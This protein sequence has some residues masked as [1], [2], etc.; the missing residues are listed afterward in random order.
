MKHTEV[1]KPEY[2]DEYV[3]THRML[4]RT[5]SIMISDVNFIKACVDLNDVELHHDWIS[6]KYLHGVVF[7]DLIMRTYKAFFDNK[8]TDATNLFK[9]KNSVKG[10]YLKPEYV[11]RVKVDI[12]TSRL[13]A[14]KEYKKTRLE[15]LSKNIIY[16]HDKYVGH[17]ILNAKEE[18]KVNLSDIKELLEYGCELF[19]RLSFEPKG[20]YD[21]LLESDGYD[22][23]REFSYTEKSLSDFIRYTML[24]SSYVKSIDCV[25]D[26]D[27]KEFAVGKKLQRMIDD[28]NESKSP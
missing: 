20:F 2:I 6:L 24:S 18:F 8:G 25:I 5:L 4:Y 23:S 27:C 12:A 26:E 14:D 3:E 17:G 10:K 28:I 15:D 13:E 11:D 7:E 21:P 9:F 1:I 16:L 22:F 19:Q